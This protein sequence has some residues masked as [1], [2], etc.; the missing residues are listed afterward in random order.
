MYCRFNDLIKDLEVFEK[1]YSL[2]VQEE[3]KKLTISNQGT[4]SS[5]N[6]S[7]EGENQN[8]P[9]RE[10]NDRDTTI[11]NDLPRACKFVQNH[12]KELII[13]DPS[14]K[15]R[16][17]SSSRQLIDNFALVS[18]FEPKNIVDALKDEN[19]I[20][21]MEEELNQFKRNKVW[22]LV[23]RPQDH[24]II[25]TKLRDEDIEIVEPSTKASKKK[26]TNQGGKA[27]QTAQRKRDAPTVE[28]SDEQME[29]HHSEENPVSRNEEEIEEPTHAEVTVTKSPG[30]RKRSTQ[31]R[32]SAQSN[33]EKIAED[34]YTP[35]PSTRK[36]PRTTSEVQNTESSVKQTAKRK[37][38][39]RAPETQPAKEPTPLPKFIDD[40]A[41]DRFELSFFNEKR[42]LLVPLISEFNENAHQKEPRPQPTEHTPG[43]EATPE[44]H[45]SSSQP[46]DKGKAPITEKETEEDDEE[47]EEEDHVDPEQFRLTRRK[48]GS[49]KITI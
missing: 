12:P 38:S 15:V 1:N 41:R 9:V 46:K 24:P 34:Q 31:K 49:S 8:S 2:G 10:D 16:T 40:E 35:E 6:D 48:P 32:S 18:H 21:A 14:E 45:A 4:T 47:T 33:A 43:T 26:S 17:R 13:G 20:L 5:E 27:K 3:L 22:I 11:P 28:P 30:K 23:V 7:K 37:R 44:A 39:A 25:G 42:N 29:E 36:S 19:W